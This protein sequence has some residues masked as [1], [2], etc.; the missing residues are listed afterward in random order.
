MNNL[1]TIAGGNPTLLAWDEV[2]KNEII[3]KYLG[4]E[5]E[6]V[7]FITV[8]KKTP[9]LSMMGN[10]LC[11]N[12]MLALTFELGNTGSFYASGLRKKVFYEKTEKANIQLKLLY[13]LKNNFVLLPGIGYMLGKNKKS[14]S[15]Q[16][17]LKLCIKYRK[18]AFG[19]LF[20]KNDSMYPY[21]YVRKTDSFVSETACGSGSIAA[22]ILLGLEDIKQT[23]GKIINVKRK[24]NDFTVSAEVFKL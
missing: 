24:N 21:V 22:N 19:V 23:T 4:N 17:L 14:T 6:Q 18:A 2:N 15:K 9:R 11:I 12:A 7:G 5:A 13:T 1:Y 10:E 16:F 20:F 3:K 8:D